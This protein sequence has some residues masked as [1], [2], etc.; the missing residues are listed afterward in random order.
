MKFGRMEDVSG[1]DFSL[2][3]LASARFASHPPHANEARLWIGA[4]VWNHPGFFE[5]I[6]PA[7]LKSAQ[8]LEHYARN[9]N[10]IE[11]NSTFYG[12]P[13]PA[14]VA[15]WCA[16]VDDDFRFCPKAPR[17]ITHDSNAVP[18]REVFEFFSAI[19][20]FGDKLGACFF[21]LSPDLGPRQWRWL[22]ALLDTCPKEH[23]VSI[24]LRHK[25]WFDSERGHD[26]LFSTLADYN[27][28]LVVTDTAGRRDVLHQIFP[29]THSMVR[30][31][32]N[33]LIASD[34]SRMD[35]WGARLKQWQ[36]RGFD[37]I[38]FFIHQPQ[39]GDCVE[40]AEHMMP[41]F[42]AMRRVVRVSAAEQLA[43]F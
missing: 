25:E 30:F 34:Y 39:E 4:P 33:S 17:A 11:L 13:R 5:K 7:K 8:L 15:N 42:P 38:Y 16:A 9:F 29:S 6:Y 2:P 35:A 21:Q 19:D 22:K 41:S 43:L 27:C 10:C 37:D 31:C 12:I 23:A 3:D 24:E 20:G 26:W 1:V 36:G 14:T 18:R 28:G 40:L 32:G